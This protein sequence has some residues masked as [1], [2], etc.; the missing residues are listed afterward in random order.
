MKTV[1]FVLV[2]AV[3]LIPVSTATAQLPYVEVTFDDYGRINSS[4]CPPSPVFDE[5]SIFAVNFNM[6]MA[7]IEYMVDYSVALSYL[8]DIMVEPGAL[9][10][11]NSPTGIA[12]SYPNV[13]N[14]WG[15]FR[16]QKVSVWWN[17][18]DCAGFENT[19]V[20]VL[21]HPLS[22]KVRAVQWPSL[23]AVDAIGMTSTI[24]PYG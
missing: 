14:A 5:L 4:Y 2:A 21:P 22:G 6:W 8:G 19:R 24:C 17:C 23:S 3:V 16:T 7:A 11:G 1:F 20:V 12:I 10:I 13:G 9:A 18:S 15:P